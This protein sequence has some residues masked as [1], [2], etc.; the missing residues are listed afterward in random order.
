MNGCSRQR[1]RRGQQPVEQVANRV[2]GEARSEDRPDHLLHRPRAC[3]LPAARADRGEG[4]GLLV[5]EIVGVLEQRP[6]VVL[7]LLGG[8]A[9][10]SVAQL[11]PVLTADLVQRLGRELHD[12]IVVDHDRG[13]WRVLA[14]ALGVPAG[15]VH[16][17]R[18]EPGGAREQARV[19]LGAVGDPRA[20]D[21]LAG[22]DGRART[23]RTMIAGSGFHDGRP[24]AA[25]GSTGG[26]SSSAKN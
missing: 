25:G 13:L 9:L 26:G 5:A 21:P 10:A 12:V 3:D 11:V 4:G 7:E 6:A 24:T 1:E 2:D 20:S 15:H 17:D 14:G 18:C 19:E 16:R 22:R 23:E 8:G